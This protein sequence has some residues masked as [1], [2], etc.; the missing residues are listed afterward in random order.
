M[1]HHLP[2][3]AR[4]QCA[5]EMRRV[6]KPGGRVLA[7]DFGS[8]GREQKGLF[9]RFHRHGHVKPP[10]IIEL[11]STAGLTVVETGRVGIHDMHF[12]LAKAS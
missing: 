12:V 3:N 8:R 6:L 7:V 9:A 11:L 10:E 4:R 2:R 5:A 1:L